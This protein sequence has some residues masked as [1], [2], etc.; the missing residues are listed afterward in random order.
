MLSLSVAALTSVLVALANPANAA[1][2]EEHPTVLK[3][4]TGALIASAVSPDFC[5]GVHELKDG[6]GLFTLNCTVNGASSSP[7]FYNKWDISPGNN[8]V[9]RLSGL[10][11]GSGDF[12]LDAGDLS[13]SLRSSKIW[14]C[15]PGLPQQQWYYTDD[16]HI[17]ITGGQ[18]CLETGR[19]GTPI[20]QCS[21]NSGAGT[22][23]WNIV[24]G[25]GGG[26][27]PPPPPTPPPAT[28][29]KPIKWVLDGKDVCLTV[30]NGAFSNGAALTIN[31]CF[32]PSSN[33]YAFQQFVYTEGA[34]K[35]QVAPNSLTTT[36]YCV[37]FGSDRGV[38]GVG[39]KIWQ[40]YDNVPAQNLYITGDAHLAVEGDNQCLDVR[41]ESGPSQNKP[42]GSLKDV[43]S[44]QCSGGDANQIFKF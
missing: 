40:C 19:Y 6:A 3:R 43:Q 18:G 39:A 10:P 32:E 13:G 15:Y 38:N 35:V 11:A 14:T 29:G 2:I 31:S 5:V 26:T 9:V 30:A 27:T 17:A 21:S 36:N 4:A 34:T 25:S 24:E 23:T 42:Y 37:D 20:N 12:C 1:P 7:A 16:K 28:T 33:Y 44:W 8:Q 41:A 22:Q